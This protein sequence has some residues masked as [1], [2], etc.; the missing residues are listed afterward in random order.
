MS[1]WKWRGSS[2]K[3]FA[4][5]SHEGETSSLG[6]PV[7]VAEHPAAK[8]RDP[9]EVADWLRHRLVHQIAPNSLEQLADPEARAMVDQAAHTVLAAEAQDITGEAK[10]EIVRLVVDEIVGFGPIDPLLRDPTVTEVMVN[11]PH[12]VYYEREGKIYESDLC[13]QNQEHIMRVIDRIIA[14]IG[15][16]V[17]EASPMVDARLPDGSRVNIIIPPLSPDSPTI[18]IR[19]F[20]RYLLQIDDLVRIGTMPREISEF[21][22]ACIRAKINM[23]ISGGT[24]TG[25]TTLLNAF[26]TFLPPGE[27]IV[28]IENPLELQ[29]QRRHVVRLEARPPGLEGRGE[30]TQRD[31]FRNALR[32]RP[33][34]IIVGEVRG[35][36]AFDMLQAMNTG[37]EGSLTTLHANSPRDALSR[38]EDM[39][40]LA[41]FDIPVA[42]IREEMASALHLIVQMS[43]LSDGSRRVTQ[44][45]EI[46]GMEGA[47][48]TMQDIFRFQIT[49]VAADGTIEGGFQATGIRPH[50]T[51]KLEMLGFGAGSE[52]FFRGREFASTLP[53]SPA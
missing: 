33:D 35:S 45:T 49:G 16:H 22:G 34:R 4:D 26:S 21:L 46:S 24:G 6:A 52:I 32:M 20:S 25:K 2:S 7:Q 36:E 3:E 18:T 5:G 17:D 11:G 43:R 48:V 1:Q 31:L 41:G 9:E 40:L 23:A 12:L 30:V 29:L 50:F 38:I 37:H 13:F 15:R 28:T 42:T 44:V 51:E 8:A 14:P 53:A 47:A 27:R 19:K 39:V 10:E